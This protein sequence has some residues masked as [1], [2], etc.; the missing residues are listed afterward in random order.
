[1]NLHTVDKLALR[2]MQHER[3]VWDE[4]D[5]FSKSVVLFSAKTMQHLKSIRLLCRKGLAKEAIL[6]L[7]ALFEDLVTLKYMQNDKA[8]VKDFV[9]FDR[10]ERFQLGERLLKSGL[11][12]DDREKSETRQRELGQQ[13]NEVKHRFTQKNG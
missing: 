3:D 1:H 9:D 2:I 13:W 7:R 10:Y 8:R 12:L 5:D 4:A 6:P 11:K